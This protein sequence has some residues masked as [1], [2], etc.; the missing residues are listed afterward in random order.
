MHHGSRLG[1]PQMRIYVLQRS[2][3]H[4]HSPLI[5]RIETKHQFHQSSLSTPARTYNSCHFM[6]G[7]HQRD[8]IQHI[9][10]IR[11]IVTEAHIFHLYIPSLR[12]NGQFGSNILLLIR[13]P[14]YLIQPF[15]TYLGV[16]KLLRKSYKRRDRRTE[17][18][19][20]ISQR[21]HHTQ[22]HL[23]FHHRL[24]RNKRDY[25]I[26][27]LIEK[28]RTYLLYLPQSQPFYAD[29]K[30]FHLNT[31]PL[32]ALLCL[33][34]VQLYLLH[35]SYHLHK[36]TLLSGCL[37]KP[38]DIQFTAIFHKSKYPSDIQAVT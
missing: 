18:T 8:I 3:T 5:G 14:M 21:H 34:I 4:L 27:G 15:Q 24:C 17:L 33:A 30:Q 10:S 35:G 23:P 16:L 13:F 36:V 31:L 32:P 11:S 22:C 1:T 19:D 7:N 26:R 38:T 9:V 2:I 28:Y 6:F 12:Q 25:N 29:F 20:D 37:C